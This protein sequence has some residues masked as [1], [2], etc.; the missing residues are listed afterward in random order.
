METWNREELYKEIWEQPMLKLAPKYGISSVMLGKVCRKLR[1]PVPGRGYWAR[2]ASGHLVSIKPL[3]KLKEV[4]IVQ[5]FKF[6]DPHHMEPKMPEPE[7]T[8]PEYVRIK[9]VESLE[10]SI[11]P[12]VPLHRRVAATAKA[13]KSAHTDYRGYRSTRGIEGALD[14]HISNGTSGRAIQI[15]NAVVLA[16][17]NQGFSLSVN[18]DTR[19]VVAK[20]FEREIGFELIEKYNQI[21]IPEYQRKDDFFAPKVRYE[22]NGILEFRVSH[23]R[24]G[25]FAMR[26]HKKLPLESQ[27]AVMV[28]AF[29]RQARAAKLGAE[30]ERREEIKRRE[31]EIQH[32]KL[33]ELIREEEKKVSNLD[34]W[35]TNW[36]RARHYREF[37]A[38]LEQ[39]WKEAGKN[40]SQEADHGK[41]LVWMLQQADRLDPLVESPSS[42]LDRKSEI[43]GRWY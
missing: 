6:A 31:D 39:S 28:G 40:L 25:Q 41:R 11:D 24:Y 35:V 5:R 26:D 27:I 34:T 10:I 42:I 20:V 29:V 7:P 2:K 14:L 33:A 15:L 23:S 43:V 9:E 21:R 17:E 32:Q 30:R 8:D 19:D 13:F 12:N 1:I 38:A 37:I 4:P 3:P 22:P 16:L 18:K 36:L